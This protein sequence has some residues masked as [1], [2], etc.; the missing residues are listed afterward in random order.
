MKTTRR[1]LIELMHFHCT[2]PKQK[3]LVPGL[4]LFRSDAPTEPVRS[5]Y[6][7]RLCVVLQGRKELILD[8]QR[9]EIGLSDYLVVV[10]DLPVT[11]RIVEAS[12]GQPHYAITLDL[13]P[14]II[15]ELVADKKELRSVAKTKGA[16]IAGLTLD[17]LEPLERLVRLLDRPT[18]IETLAPLVRR[19]LFYKLVQGSLG[20]MVVESGIGG[21][22]LSRIART[23]AWIKANFDQPV[24]I[25]TLADIAGMSQT[26]YYRAFKAATTMSPLQ[27]RTRLRLHEARRRLQ[28]GVDKIG[29]IAFAVGYENQSQFNREY[30]KLFGRPPGVD[31]SR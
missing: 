9:I 14:A 15:A 8:R 17:I 16:A 18:D 3:T 24:D 31:L 30:R 10:L 7:P 13:D 5:L 25:A 27:F 1:S 11:A 26:S 29:S 12:P 28:L 22:R 6:D 2:A 4:T 19:E 20:D 21:S 23:T